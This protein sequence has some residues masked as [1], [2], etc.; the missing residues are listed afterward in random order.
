MM[1]ND[2]WQNEIVNC[3]KLSKQNKI[4]KGFKS[5]FDKINCNITVINKQK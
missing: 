2:E 3:K 1:F 5:S 4:V